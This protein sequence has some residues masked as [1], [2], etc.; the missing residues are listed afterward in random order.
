MPQYKKNIDKLKR[1]DIY[2]VQ[3]NEKSPE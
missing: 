2:I 1:M 3:F